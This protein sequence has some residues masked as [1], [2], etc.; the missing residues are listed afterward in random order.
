MSA[1]PSIREWFVG[2]HPETGEVDAEEVA[3]MAIDV[4]TVQRMCGGTV[5]S[6]AQRAQDPGTGE[7]LT[8]GLWWRWHPFAPG[9][10]E[11]ERPPKQQQGQGGGRRRRSRGRGGKGGGQP[12]QHPM[13]PQGDQPVT[14]AA[15]HPGAA[16]ENQIEP[17]PQEPPEA[18][19]DDRDADEFLPL[20]PEAEADLRAEGVLP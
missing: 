16:F 9:A 12:P 20:S 4:S 19:E 3:Q 11:E 5:T 6:G 10:I 8:L 14:E 18:F 13:I 2:P 17:E 7:W 15:Q 1:N